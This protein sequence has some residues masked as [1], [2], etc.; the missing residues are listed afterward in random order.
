M[1]GENGDDPFG[2]GGDSGSDTAN[3][4]LALSTF[5]DQCSTP[6]QSFTSGQVA[7]IEATLLQDGNPVQGEIVTFSG[8]LGTLS[9]TTKLTDSQGV[10]QIT[11][12]SEN[13]EIGAAELSATY[14]DASATQNYEYLSATTTANETAVVSTAMLNNGQGVNRFQADTDVQLQTQIVDENDD[15]IAGVIVTFSAQRGTLN[16]D[17]ALTLSLIHISEPTRPY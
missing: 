13:T 7:C 1:S 16:T 9:S 3:Y 6:T 10:A 15:P 4:T 11:I 14:D 17:S 12:S 2:S 8:S 5:D